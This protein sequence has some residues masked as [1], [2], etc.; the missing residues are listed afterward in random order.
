M[1]NKK[2][3]ERIFANLTDLHSTIKNC[4]NTNQAATLCEYAKHLSSCLGVCYKAEKD[5]EIEKEKKEEEK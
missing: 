3:S 5:L 1:T 2:M 4:D